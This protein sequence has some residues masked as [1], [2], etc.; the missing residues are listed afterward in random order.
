M[1]EREDLRSTA[2]DFAVVRPHRA[3]HRR[4]GTRASTQVGRLVGL[5]EGCASERKACC[6]DETHLGGA[7]EVND[8]RVRHLVQN[9]FLLLHMRQ[10]VLVEDLRL[11]Q[12]LHR[13]HRSRVTVCRQSYAPETVP[14][15]PVPCTR[16]VWPS[17]DAS[18]N[19]S[20]AEREPDTP[21]A[22]ERMEYRR[23]SSGSLWGSG[24]RRAPHA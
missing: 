5:D 4:R 6:V 18:E 12:Y 21:H 13:A 11:G 1:W 20:Q 15:T 10:L 14:H 24:E 22:Y 9:G 23:K 16:E 19:P 3:A 7:E 2:A 8:E 17:R